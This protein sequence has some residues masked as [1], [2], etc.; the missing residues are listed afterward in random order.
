MIISERCQASGREPPAPDLRIF[1]RAPNPNWV[2]SAT[3]RRQWGGVVG[4]GA[5][6]MTLRREKSGLGGE[7]WVRWS[8]RGRRSRGSRKRGTESAGGTGGV[9]DVTAEGEGGVGD[10][11]PGRGGERMGGVGVR[12]AAIEIR[13]L[14]APVRVGSIMH[15][16]D[17]GCLSV[18]FDFVKVRD[19]AYRL[20]PPLRLMAHDDPFLS[21]TLVSPASVAPHYPLWIGRGKGTGHVSEGAPTATETVCSRT[22]SDRTETEVGIDLMENEAQRASGD[23]TI[24][25]Y[26]MHSVQGSEHVLSRDP[27]QRAG[28]GAVVRRS[29]RKALQYSA[30]FELAKSWT[31][32]GA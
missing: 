32:L 16:G 18:C 13:A 20:S 21:L 4:G 10:R 3:G 8:P 1:Q 15:A 7:G 11:G 31:V 22:S 28:A 23:R 9:T 26:R 2:V 27:P 5:G 25:E 6:G 19:G 12:G 24:P 14:L 17:G 29:V 30:S